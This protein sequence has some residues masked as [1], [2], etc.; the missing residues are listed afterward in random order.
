VYRNRKPGNF[1]DSSP[2]TCRWRWP[3]RGGF[4]TTR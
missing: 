4:S 3:G 1:F 2:G